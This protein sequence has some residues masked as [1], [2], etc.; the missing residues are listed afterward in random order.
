MTSPTLCHIC[1]AEVVCIPVA[2]GGYLAK[3]PKARSWHV[4][5][6]RLTG[7]GQTEAEAIGSFVLRSER[8]CAN[9]LRKEGIAAGTLKRAH[10]DEAVQREK[11]RKASEKRKENRKAEREKIAA[12][13]V[14]L[15][16]PCPTCGMTLRVGQRVKR[17]ETGAHLHDHFFAAWCPNRHNGCTFRPHAEI[18]GT[19]PQE[20]IERWL[21]GDNRRGPKVRR[22]IGADID[23]IDDTRVY[24][25]CACGLRI[26][27][28]GATCGGWHPSVQDHVRSGLAAPGFNFGV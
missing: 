10:D 13:T 18:R 26:F 7:T 4:R 28:G 20:A 8:Y 14:G 17:S 22:D 16:P 5:D 6:V 27:D 12:E 19:T 9:L 15:Y 25:L 21:S 23:A 1:Q 2:S 3:C 11:Y 24:P